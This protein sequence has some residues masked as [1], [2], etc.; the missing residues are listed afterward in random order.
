VINE[1]YS[2]P[3]DPTT[4]TTATVLRQGPGNPSLTVGLDPTGMVIH[5]VAN[6][7]LVANTG[8]GLGTETLVG[9]TFRQSH[10]Q[11]RD[12]GMRPRSFVDFTRIERDSR[13]ILEDRVHSFGP[14]LEIVRFTNFDS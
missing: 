3:L 10:Y 2:R 6:A 1:G 13:H 5:A 11:P 14:A 8:S 12:V 9:S 4:V 7:T